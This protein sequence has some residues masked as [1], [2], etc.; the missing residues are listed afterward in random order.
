[1]SGPS[2][3]PTDAAGPS[4]A[5]DRRALAALDAIRAIA[6]RVEVAGRLAP[7]AG[8]V[9]LRS[10]VDATVILFRA[11]AASLALH[12][13]ATDKLVFRVAAG[14]QGDAVVGL[15]I[16]P[17]E[18][19]AGYVFTT[20]QPLALSDVASD[21]RF[22]RRTAEQTGYT[23]RSLVA[24]PLQDDEGTIG[25]LE[26]LDKRDDGRFD[27]HDI[28]L[29]SVFARQ[30]TVAIRASR[31][32]RDTATM[33]RSALADIAAAGPADADADAGTLDIDVDAIVA[34]AV[35]ELGRDDDR[36]LWPLADEIA[37]LRG[38][39]PGELDLLRELLAVLANRADRAGDS[40]SRRRM[41]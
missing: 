2:D 1:V 19:V 21:V 39:D 37:R 27:L 14:S 22:G 18:G 29:A 4:A 16:A 20:G 8:A 10:V 26:V 15:A 9:V 25:V 23:P 28:E 34:A 6:L 7:P 5:G 11:E 35:A 31:V 24:V 30:A 13:S 36:G 3:H 17:D 32:E 33:L 38:A 40:R 41:R 12:D